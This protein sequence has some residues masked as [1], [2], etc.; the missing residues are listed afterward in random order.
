LVSS[1]PTNPTTQ[2]IALDALLAQHA[3]APNPTLAALEQALSERNVFSSQNTQLWKLIE[4]Q[5]TGYNQVHR[6]LERLR[7]ERDAYKSR[8]QAAG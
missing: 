2:P 5:R 8:L 4:K 1:T 3:D 7:A 6:E